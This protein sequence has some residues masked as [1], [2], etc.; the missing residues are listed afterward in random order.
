MVTKM[1]LGEIILT[2]GLLDIYIPPTGRSS[3]WK[4][5]KATIDLKTCLECLRRH[6]KIYAIDEQ[7]DQE[8]PIHWC[9]RCV[10]DALPSVIAGFGSKNGNDG[11]DWWLKH[12]GILPDYYIT[13]SQI[14]ALGWRHGMSP[15]KYAPD[16]MVTMGIYLNKDGH[17]PD[18]PGRTWHEADLNY[19]SGKRNAHRILW[20]NDG[21]IF[22]TYDHYATFME[23]V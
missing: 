21:L 22:V 14:Q 7:P 6:G 10:V 18:A 13:A 23:I 17:L 12:H 9:C 3:R 4:N 8:P 2:K 15:A 20:S 11:A 5:W 1:V 19:Y 16:K